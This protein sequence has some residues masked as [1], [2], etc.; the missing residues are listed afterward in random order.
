MKLRQYK[1]DTKSIVE[2]IK[3][4]YMKSPGRGFRTDIH[5]SRGPRHETRNQIAKTLGISHGT[6]THLLYIDKHCPKLIEDIPSKYS[7]DGAY[8]YAKGQVN[9]EEYSPI[10]GLYVYDCAQTDDHD[11][12][13]F[14]IGLSKGIE[15][16]MRE[17]ACFNPKGKL[18]HSYECAATKLIKTESA[19]HHSLSAYSTSYSN[20][21]FALPRD[22]DF[23]TYFEDLLGTQ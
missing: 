22:F 17:A 18:I 19:I 14:K 8:S 20:E 16:R 5:R 7:I 4:L 2:E 23:N 3:R 21:V 12:S 10:C 1:V 11:R 6:I 15:N 9:G 13:L